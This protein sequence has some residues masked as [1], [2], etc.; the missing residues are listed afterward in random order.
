[1]LALYIEF[2]TPGF[3][4]FGI[5]GISCLAIVFLGSYVAGLSGHEPMLVFGLGLILVA[6][7]IF[8]FPGVVVLALTGLL[9][10]LG[11]LVWAMADLWPNEPLSVAWRGDAFVG[12]LSNLGLAILIAVGLAVA[13]A[14]FL[15]R[16]WF[17]DKLVMQAAIGGSAQT[18]GSGGAETSARVATLVG[19]E[20][21][22]ATALRPGG[23]VEVDGRRYEARVEIG[24]IERGTPIVVRASSDFGLIV[25]EKR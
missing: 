6:V 14:R 21:I 3:G 11:S 5:V 18:A 16:G 15:P 1:M 19:R 4:V 9:L 2:K 22:A 25:E 20:G 7:E 23:Q 13:V 17:W 10:M 12:P 8:F 24:I